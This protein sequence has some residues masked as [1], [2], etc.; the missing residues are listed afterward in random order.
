MDLLQMS[1]AGAVMIL[2]I[3]AM[4]ALMM[5][6]VPKKTFQLL[7]GIA[8]ARLLIPFSLPFRFSIYAL[9]EQK[10]PA[11]I[12]KSAAVRTLAA[13]SNLQTAAVPQTAQVQSAAFSPWKIVWFIGML[14]CTLYFAIAYW[15]CIRE[16]QTALPVENAFAARWL[17]EHSLRRSIS[18]RQSSLI[19]T[20]LTFGV[21]R[22]VILM[23]KKTD[24]ADEN[25]LR[26]V[27]EH[28]FVHIRRFD[29]LTKR[30]LIA[31][32]CVHWFN[33]LVWIMYM[34]ANRDIE[35]S[36]DEAVVRHFGS[37]ARANYAKVLIRME[38]A[39]SGFVPLLNHFSKNAIEERITAIMKTG[40]TTILSMVLAMMLVVGT[41]GAFATSAT[42]RTNAAVETAIEDAH[43]SSYTDENGETRYQLD[44]GN[45]VQNLSGEELEQEL[46]EVYIGEYWTYEGYKAWLENE[47]QQLQSVIGESAWTSGM[48][49]FV[50]TQELVDETIAMYEEILEDIKNGVKVSKTVEDSMDDFVVS[51]VPEDTESVQEYQVFIKLENGDEKLIGP[52]ATADDLLS[53]L[54]S[55][56]DAQVKQGNMTRDE[57]DA[58]IAKYKNTETNAEIE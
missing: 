12:Q 3:V 33:P 36:C 15:R 47:K 13:T 46:N 40:K 11:V 53:A 6:R 30:L 37:G 23:P 43:I 41:A 10:T 38:E 49:D 17:R 52:Y 21:R 44:D 2:A 50:W 7:W 28:E 29:A 42:T 48:G 22:P 18:I 4:R 31:A 27:L 9:L 57:A 34:L 25:A 20:P 35:L 58:I 14:V 16:F 5:N 24:W 32:V 54:Q 56:C 51:Y 55:F 8:L 45:A 1:V 19:S 26:Y 39:R